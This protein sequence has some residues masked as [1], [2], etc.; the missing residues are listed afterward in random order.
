MVVL[1]ATTTTLSCWKLTRKLY[2][3]CVERERA[4]TW[5][6]ILVHRCSLVP[7]WV[8]Q[9]YKEQNEKDWAVQMENHGCCVRLLVPTQRG[10]AVVKFN[11]STGFI[12]HLLIGVSP[13]AL[14]P[15]L[16]RVW[17]VTANNRKTL[18]IC[19]FPM[20]VK[21]QQPLPFAEDNKE[22]MLL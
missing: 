12:Q 21:C 15:C 2:C 13:L 14:L 5:R 7:C 1:V 4:Q 3:F 20:A 19:S 16:C 9:V 11:G 8:T 6:I 22:Q 18:S 17:K 10:V